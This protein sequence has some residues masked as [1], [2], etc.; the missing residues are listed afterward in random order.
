MGLEIPDTAIKVEN[1]N[2]PLGPQA[3]STLLKTVLT[4]INKKQV[5]A[6]SIDE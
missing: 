2:E 3:W 5:P 6:L 4:Q 1:M